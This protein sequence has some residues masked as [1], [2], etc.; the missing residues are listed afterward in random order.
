MKT[1]FI[2]YRGQSSDRFGLRVYNEMVYSSPEADISFEELPGVDGDV[3]MDNK[4]Y[5]GVTREWPAR[6][7]SPEGDRVEKQAKKISDWLKA[8]TGWGDLEW[9]GDPGYIYRAIHYQPIDV[10]R[11][12]VNFGSAT[13]RFRLK[14]FKYLDWGL[15][16]RDI[17]E[18]KILN[19]PERFESQPLI[20][21]TVIGSV[22][23]KINDTV[24]PLKNTNG[25]LM[26]DCEAEYCSDSGGN[27]NEKAEF[28]PYPRLVPG[29]N[30]FS[31]SG[32]GTL[33]KIVVTPRW[34]CLV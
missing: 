25:S 15:N 24:F 28:Y 21:L 19:N 11:M 5:K 6:L 3:A 1:D 30:V 17:T 9:T 8:D 34:R 29:E 13:L 18:T 20:E 14:P 10:E 4:R 23:L 27:A 31:W 33:S 32:A 22:D 12:L 16:A 26:I 2:T 7:I